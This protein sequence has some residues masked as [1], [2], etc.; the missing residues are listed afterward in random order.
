MA[1]AHRNKRSRT[2]RVDRELSDSPARRAFFNTLTVELVQYILRLATDVPVAFDTSWSWVLDEDRVRTRRLIIDSLQTKASL[3]LVSKPFHL[4]VDQYLY[5]ALLLRC[6]PTCD[7]IR[8]L[9]SHLRARK[10]GRRPARGDRVRRLELHFEVSPRDEW[11]PAWDTLWGL[12]PVCPNLEALYFHPRRVLWPHPKSFEDLHRVWCV[13]GSTS[14]PF[15]TVPSEKFVRNIARTWGRTLRR[16]DISCH[17]RFPLSYFQPMLA[18]MCSL[19]VIHIAKLEDTLPPTPI[20]CSRKKW[21]GTLPA[22]EQ[23]RHLHTLFLESMPLPIAAGQRPQLKHITIWNRYIRG[24]E[25]HV[26]D[27]LRI[28][29]LSIV[30]L[31]YHQVHNTRV[32]LPDILDMLPNLEHLRL[33]DCWRSSWDVMLPTRSHMKIRAITVFLLDVMSTH[34]YSLIADVKK[35]LDRVQE[36]RIPALKKIQVAGR[37]C[38]QFLRPDR[39]GARLLRMGITW[40][41][42]PDLIAWYD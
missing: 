16:L 18:S 20:A 5:E 32:V 24:V 37:T 19:Q 2:E 7:A 13:D 23:M 25:D 10:R 14:L 4:L 17:V 29:A 41:L 6:P 34:E 33:R 28:H 42:R 27:L 8:R 36:G 35:L 26:R 22:G 11:T 31:Y 12:L 9:P 40:E 39:L 21:I 3:S 30:S 1:W 38:E 15:W